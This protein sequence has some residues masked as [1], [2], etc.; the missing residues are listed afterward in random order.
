MNNL[1]EEHKAEF[2]KVVEFFEQEMQKLRLGRATPALVEQIVVESYGVPTPIKHLAS[3]AVI[4][5][6]TL[7]IQP[8]DKTLLK[9]IEK[10]VSLADIGATVT[11]EADLVRVSLGSLTEETR[12]EVVKKLHQKS[13]EAKISFRAIRDK[14]RTEVANQE[15]NKEI[16]EDEKYNFF[17]QIDELIKGYNDQVKVLTAEKEEEIMTV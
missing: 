11:A 15:K 16:S 14:A 4:D 10:A 2:N 5:S 12:R 3:V 17:Q 8:W 6:K 13:E 7:T 1:I 9:P